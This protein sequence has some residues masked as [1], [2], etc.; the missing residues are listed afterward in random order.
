MRHITNLKPGVKARVSDLKSHL[1][2]KNESQVI[3]YLLGLYDI[4]WE[5][6]TVRDSERC[7]EISKDL[8][9]DDES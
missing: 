6:L 4:N 3:G 7:Y 1:K 2:L 9:D 8:N 5:T